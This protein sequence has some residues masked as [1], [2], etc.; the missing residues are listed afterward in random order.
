[1]SQPHT[2]D[3][4][5][6]D[7]DGVIYTGKKVIPSAA[8]AL[9]NW[10]AQGLEYT[11]IT[12]NAARDVVEIADTI[13]SYGIAVTPD[14]VRTSAQAAAEALRTEIPAGSTVLALG[15]EFLRAC[16]W[17]VGLQ[18]VTPDQADV[19]RES[20]PAAVVQGFGPDTSWRDLAAAI[21]AVRAGALYRPTNPDLSI[22]TGRGILPG[23]GTFVEI[24]ASFS[25]AAPVFAGKPEPVMLHQAVAALGAEHPMMIGDQ[26]N[27]DIEAANAAGFDSAL[28]LTGVCTIHDALAAPAR[29]RP[30]RIISTLLDLEAELPDITLSADTAQCGSASVRISRGAV[31]HSGDAL[32]AANAA[33]AFAAYTD[34]PLR[35]GTLPERLS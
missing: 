24:V 4:V 22:P 10:H 11:F 33:L 1:M 2:C 25:G 15:S 8:Q 29:Q 18:V 7:L 27:T 16:L 34:Q 28:V 19:L 6:L 3:A 23:N 13:S 20:T 35:G 26:L 9:K 17:D 5:L 12:N 21:T 30:T 31:E 14:H 32:L